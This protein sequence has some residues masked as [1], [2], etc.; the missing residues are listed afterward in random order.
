MLMT[1]SKCCA[2]WEFNQM[3]IQLLK[4][5]IC[6]IN[7]QEGT[8]SNSLN[9]DTIIILVELIIMGFMHIFMLTFF[10]CAKNDPLGK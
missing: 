10:V 4:Y 3:V 9:A 2:V 6:I 7:S 1:I 8:E 5:P